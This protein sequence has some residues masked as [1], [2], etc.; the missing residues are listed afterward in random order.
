M[1]IDTFLIPTDGSDR[2]EDAARRGF[3][4]AVQCSAD[5]H[6]LS[7][8]DSSVATGAG[9]AG[10]SQSIRERLR[11]TATARATS[12]R[13]EATERGLE[14]TAATREGI[15]AK[16]IVDYA[17][18]H[19]IDAI[20]IGTSGRGGV[21]RAVIGS[22]ADK[23]V[24][25]ASVPVL[26]IS[27][28]AADVAEGNPTVNSILLPTDGSDTA[29]AAARLGMEFAADL[30]A[31]VHLL[32]VIDSDRDRVLSRLSGSDSEADLDADERREGAIDALETLATDARSLGLNVVTETSTGHP[33]DEIVDYAESASIDLIA[34]GTAGRGGF[35]RYLLGSVTDSVVRT[36][37]VP[38]LTIRANEDE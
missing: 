30:E 37:T 8:A 5:V 29:M 28:D 16:E 2:A 6:V 22:V 21:A 17:A 23:V 3:D 35:D 7:V 18:E 9:Y 38:V 15:P 14:T 36:A 12:L 24:R 33:A 4:L 27:P 10:D 25:T 13:D 20:A 31:S 1:T 34:M 26:T 32:S 11:E 19:D